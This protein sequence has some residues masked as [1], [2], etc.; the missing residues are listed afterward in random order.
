MALILG[1]LDKERV[2][3]L[4]RDLTGVGAGSGQKGDSGT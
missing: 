4:N 3:A 2:H 1:N